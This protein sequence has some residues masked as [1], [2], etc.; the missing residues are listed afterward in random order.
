M[1][2]LNSRAKIVFLGTGTSEGV[3]RVTCLTAQPPT[4]RVCTDAVKPGSK[5]R[6]RNTS[7]VVHREQSDGPPVNIVIDVGKFF[8]QSAIDWFPKHGLRSL[9]AVLLTHAH[10]DSTG[11][12]DDLRDWTNVMRFAGGDEYAERLKKRNNGNIPIYLRKEDLDVV[13]KTSYYLVD[14]SKMT[15]GGTVAFLDFRIIDSEPIDILGTEFIPFT[16]AH[17]PGYT[18]NGYRVGNLAY[19]SDVSEMSDEAMD[20]ISDVEILVL[21]ALRPSRTHGSHLTLEG[22]V[23]LAKTIR[24]KRTLLTDASHMIHHH[25]MNQYLSQPEVSDGLD[26]QYAYDGMA[27]EIHC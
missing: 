15:S 7:I 4:C 10:I 22:A 23:D 19:I 25:E 26:I 8:Y 21:D 14:R 1:P 5:N 12:L 24:P 2:N 11:G 13:A 18:A 17:G 3:P 6:R 16:V 9:D 20:L 27:V